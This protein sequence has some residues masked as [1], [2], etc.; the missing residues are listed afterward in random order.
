MKKSIKKA[1]TLAEILLTLTIVGVIASL[2]LPVLISDVQTASLKTAWKENYAIVSQALLRAKTD[3]SGDLS[4]YLKN[5]RTFYKLLGNYVST[6]NPNCTTGFPGSNCFPAYI[7]EL[8]N[9]YVG[10]PGGFSAQLFD[11]GTL[12]LNNGALIAIENNSVSDN[13]NGSYYVYI[14]ID[15]NGMKPPNTIGKDIFGIIAFRDRIIPMGSTIPGISLSN[16]SSLPAE[17]TCTS[18]STSGIA[19][20]AYYLQN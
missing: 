7:K 6:T 15:V 4:Y 8:N 13:Y 2:T 17:S 19:C 14:W 9:S 5:S 16:Y 12:T 3:N 1:F 11:D 18:G 10:G 20:S